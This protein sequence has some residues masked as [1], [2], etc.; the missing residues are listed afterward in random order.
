M[1]TVGIQVYLKIILKKLQK[2]WVIL[3]SSNN[4]SIK[5]KNKLNHNPN[6]N[7]GKLILIKNLIQNKDYKNSRIFLKKIKFSPALYLF[8][9]YQIDILQKGKKLIINFDEL[10]QDIDFFKL[11]VDEFDSTNS[12]KQK[13]FVLIG[14]YYFFQKKYGFAIN[15]YQ[16]CLDQNSGNIDALT[17]IANCYQSLGLNSSSTEY[18]NK[19]TSFYSWESTSSLE[20]NDFRCESDEINSITISQ[21]DF[22][23]IPKNI[24]LNIA[25]NL[26]NLEDSKPFVQEIFEYVYKT[27]S[28][29][30]NQPNSK[31]HIELF[32][33]SDDI[34]SEDNGILVNNNFEKWVGNQK[35]NY[36]K[37]N[38]KFRQD[39]IFVQKIKYNI[40]SMMPNSIPYRSSI[41]A[42]FFIY[43]EVPNEDNLDNLLVTLGITIDGEN[44]FSIKEKIL[45]YW[46][47]C[48]KDNSALFYFNKSKMISRF[49]VQNLIKNRLLIKAVNEK[50]RNLDWKVLP[51]I[52]S[53]S[54][55]KSIWDVNDK[56]LNILIE[57]LEDYFQLLNQ[58]NTHDVW[59]SNS[60]FKDLLDQIHKL[61]IDLDQIYHEKNVPKISQN[62]LK[63]LQNRI[64]IM[65]K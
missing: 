33:H 11:Y 40:F 23:L 18:F 54:S 27:S 2:Y 6:S 65:Q 41:T 9:K 50:W 12:L 49:F 58:Q 16:Y 43:V 38:I 35:K 10:K 55:K 1:V 28:P 46:L 15:H 29:A 39:F 59:S 8:F 48:V 34:S 7:L 24:L 45:E 51:C 52:V 4:L 20:N 13:F 25:L 14:D 42:A 60:F 61:L 26:K 64:Q 21:K 53:Y 57:S 47:K 44:K 62:D 19:I 22:S 37:R 36:R 3:M 30:R 17:G 32:Q 56:L 63:K 5:S 31:I